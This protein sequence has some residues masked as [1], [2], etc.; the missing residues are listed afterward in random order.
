MEKKFLFAGERPSPTAL[1]TGVTWRDGRLAGASAYCGKII[2]ESAYSGAEPAPGATV[3]RRLLRI[4]L[5][6]R[7]G[8]NGEN[9]FPRSRAGA[10]AEGEPVPGRWDGG[11]WMDNP[12]P[13][14]PPSPR[15]TPNTSPAS[16]EESWG[17]LSNRQT[18]L[19][20]HQPLFDWLRWNEGVAHKLALDAYERDDFPSLPIVADASRRPAATCPSCC[21]I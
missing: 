3:R 11:C 17:P 6:A 4:P 12:A 2:S 13:G 20:Q 7:Q 15:P 1:P 9:I 16:C 10:V 21:T 18:A 5:V 19:F 8:T 14:T